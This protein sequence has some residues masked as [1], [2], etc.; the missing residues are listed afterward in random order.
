V[1]R[2]TEA[3]R[4]LAAFGLPVK[5]Q[6]ERCALTLLAL[7]DVTKRRPWSRARQPMLRTVD[8]MEFMRREYGKAYKPN[9]RETIR[10]QTLHQFRQ[11]HI[12]DQNKDDPAR[13]TNS[14]LNVYS[15]TDEALLVVRSFGRRGFD[16]V[17][18]G[19]R[20]ELGSLQEQYA[21]RRKLHEVPLHMP[22][23]SMVGLSPGKHNRL[24]V[25]IIE[26]FGPRFAPG[27]LVLYL[28]DT[29]KKYAVLDSSRLSALR[30]PVTQHDTLPDVILFRE[31]KNW[32]FLIEAVTAHGPFSPSRHRELEERLVRC[33]AERVYV[34]AF[35]DMRNFR[36]Y[37]GDIAWETE[38]WIADNPDHMIHFNGPK[39]LGP[40]KAN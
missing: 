19:F 6:N 27:A 3:Q 8:M 30:V 23:G 5:Q 10:R 28:G 22:D 24:Q 18:A 38:A 35:L 20:L 26:S 39:F 11:A 31:E 4:L 29:A 1:S 2:V 7:A 25:A 32:L 21:K 33:S 9:S 14:G 40:Y 13:A 37:A 12:V 34:T 16:A 15:L 17:V 36:K